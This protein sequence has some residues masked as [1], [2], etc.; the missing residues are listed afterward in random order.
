MN[1]QMITS[2]GLAYCSGKQAAF[3]IKANAEVVADADKETPD[4]I[5]ISEDK[6]QHQFVAWGKNNKKPNELQSKIKVSE[7]LSANI[8]FNA[9]MTYG[10]GL[11]LMKTIQDPTTKKTKKVDVAPGEYSEI[12]AF[13]KNNNIPLYLL[14]QCVDVHTYHHSYCELVLNMEAPESRKVLEI[15]HKEAMFSRV[16]PMNANGDIEMHFYSAKWYKGS[17]EKKY[18]SGTPMLKSF[19]ASLDLQRRIGREPDIKGKKVDEK[20]YSYIIPIYFPSIGARAYYPESPWYSVFLSG[21]YDLAVAIPEF[22]K[23]LMNNQMTLKYIIEIDAKYFEDLFKSENIVDPEL[24]KERIQRE[25]DMILETLTGTEN[26]G[27][28]V[29]STFFVDLKGTEHPRIKITTLE[30]TMKGG[31]F[32]EDTNIANSMLCYAQN[33]H[34]SLNGAAPGATKSINGTEARELFIMKQAMLKAYRDLILQPLEVIKVINK[35]PA[36]V[37]FEIVDTELT[38][39]DA[40]KGSQKVAGGAV[41][42]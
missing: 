22:K 29:F 30:N 8:M 14:E 10:G 34:P 6:E 1:I 19:N 39:L 28:A 4:N 16:S 35:W 37:S 24:K 33:V 38:T 11:K 31:E 15:H 32:T 12:E 20:K 42:S 18:C 3:I 27:K 17:V 40:G 7:T 13:I 41:I 25:Y 26:T 9:Y 2:D 21:W 23:A 36:E 5:E